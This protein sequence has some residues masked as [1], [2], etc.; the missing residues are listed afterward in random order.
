M[1]SMVEGALHHVPN[2]M[3]SPLHRSDERSPSP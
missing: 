1:R 3:E 2:Q